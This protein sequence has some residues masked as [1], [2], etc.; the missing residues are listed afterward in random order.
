MKYRNRRASANVD[1][2]HGSVINEALLIEFWIGKA[3]YVERDDEEYVI[4]Q[5]A[6]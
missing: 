4:D 6:D 1:I 5:A 2:D 3:Q